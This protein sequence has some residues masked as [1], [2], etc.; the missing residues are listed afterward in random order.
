MI[1]EKG[2]PWHTCILCGVQKHLFN[3]I[4]RYLTKEG[5]ALIIFT[6]FRLNIIFIYLNEFI[7]EKI[8][9][10]IFKGIYMAKKMSIVKP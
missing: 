5:A 9:L 1:F 10:L 4:I 6:F 2:T 8:L 7:W 3:D